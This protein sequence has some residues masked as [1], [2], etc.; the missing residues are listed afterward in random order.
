MKAQAI[1]DKAAV[2]L[3]KQGRKSF[4]EGQ[5]RCAYRGEGGNCCAIGALIPDELYHPLMDGEGAEV[6]QSTDVRYLLNKFPEVAA[7]L[8][9]DDMEYIS[10]RDFLIELQAIHDS[11]QP[12]D[13]FEAL[14]RTARHYGLNTDAIQEFA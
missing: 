3:L 10:G 12:K 5:S 4:K 2:H 8:K 7:I 6:K 11:W 14:C 13:W 9:P 1:F